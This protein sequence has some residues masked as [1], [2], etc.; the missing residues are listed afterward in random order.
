MDELIDLNEVVV[1]EEKQ[2]EIVLATITAV[3][4]D[5]VQIQI[6]GE[7]EAGEK[8]Y[9]VNTSVK[10]AV[11]DR[12][13]IF[14]N[15]GTYL[16]EYKFGAPMADYP[17]P[18]G[19]SDG[20]VLTKDGSNDFAVK[21]GNAHGV[22]SGGASGY[23]LTKNSDTDYDL[24]WAQPHWLPSGGTNGQVLAKSSA[25]DYSVAWV[26][27]G[28]GV[29]SGGTTGQALTKKSNTNYD[30]QWSD[31]KGIPSGGTA[32]QVLAK[33]NATNYN[34]EWATPS[35]GLLKNGSYTL[36]LNSSGVLVPNSSGSISLGNSY[37]PIGNLY[38]SNSVQLCGSGYSAA[39][40][41]F[42]TTPIRKIT[43]ITTSS[44]LANLITA[45]KNYGLF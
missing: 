5:G 24:T 17:I 21:W 7:E 30:L 13:K 34:V 44:T 37:Y 41:F 3:G 18:A 42:G 6:D 25:T 4:T 28:H 12:V 22:P 36:T 29:P 39:L 33:T 11:G 20:Q 1:E 43:S 8:E 45:L 40:G 15:S 23:V 16:I 27:A 10:F 2:E 26:D 35:A 19:G 14:K 32:G 31:V 38:A 9:K